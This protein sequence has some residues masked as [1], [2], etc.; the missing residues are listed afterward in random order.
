M[1]P[2]IYFGFVLVQQEQFVQEANSFI[3][4]D[5]YIEG[6]YL[7][8]SDVDASKKTIRLVYGGRLIPESAKREVAAKTRYYR[9]AGASVTIQQ[10][11]SVDESDAK[12]VV[13]DQ[14]QAEINRLRQ[15]LEKSLDRKSVVTGKSVAERVELVGPGNLK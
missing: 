5:T 15:D 10:G 3:R 7:L 8:R 14:Q 12:I 2:S 4:N 6:D 9:L 1:V 13:R 11:F